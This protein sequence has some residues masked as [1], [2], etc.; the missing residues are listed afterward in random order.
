L[1]DINPSKTGLLLDTFAKFNEILQKC[2]F[3]GFKL[4]AKTNIFFPCLVAKI[5]FGKKKSGN[6]APFYS[7]LEF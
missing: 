4:L 1:R 6:T 7:I 2:L 3:A 5:H